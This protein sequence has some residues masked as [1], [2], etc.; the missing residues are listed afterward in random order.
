MTGSSQRQNRLRIGQ[1]ASTILTIYDPRLQQAYCSDTHRKQQQYSCATTTFTAKFTKQTDMMHFVLWKKYFL[2]IFN[3][4]I[5]CCLITS[6]TFRC[7]SCASRQAISCQPSR[8][9]FLDSTKKQESKSDS[10]AVAVQ[11]KLLLTEK[12][13]LVPVQYLSVRWYRLVAEHQLSSQTSRLLQK[14]SALY[15]GTGSEYDPSSFQH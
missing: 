10:I 13:S 2:G 9:I 15:D 5:F 4:P 3:L 8:K 14:N 6:F 11:F 7:F 12:T 1:T